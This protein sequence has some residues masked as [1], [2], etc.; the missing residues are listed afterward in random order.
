MTNG[1][2]IPC[3][4]DTAAPVTGE[5]VPAVTDMDQS[6]RVTLRPRQENFAQRLA[7]HGNAARAHREAFDCDPPT[8]PATIRQRA[9][10]LRNEPQVAARIRELFVQAAEGTTISARTRMVH[11]QAIAEADPTELVRKVS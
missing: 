3:N 11:L 7:A 8:K 2:R 4:D 10:E 6:G 1:L 5:L 9:Y